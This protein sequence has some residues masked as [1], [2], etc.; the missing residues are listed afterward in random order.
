MGTGV[1][2][3]ALSQAGYLATIN[4]DHSSAMKFDNE[5]LQLVMSMGD[6]IS[7]AESLN[8]LGNDYME[9]GKYDEAYYYFTQ[10]YRIARQNQDSLKMTVAIFNTGT[11]LTELGSI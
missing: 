4:G 11:V 2:P 10:S 8:N 7:I 6:S 9:L 1:R 3:H 5:N